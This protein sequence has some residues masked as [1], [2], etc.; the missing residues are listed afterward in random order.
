MTKKI[1]SFLMLCLVLAFINACS[2]IYKYQPQ[3]KEELKALVE[4]PQ[5]NLST[6]DTS[7]I[8]DMSE[9]FYQSKR[10]DFTSIEL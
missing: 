5:T 2:N 3:S 8:T 9:L 1:L 6:I 7:K 10:K 4:N